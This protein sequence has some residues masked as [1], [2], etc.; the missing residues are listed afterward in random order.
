MGK[1]RAG[2]FGHRNA[3]PRELVVRVTPQQV[4]AQNDIAGY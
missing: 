4:I 3:V 1:D 2:E